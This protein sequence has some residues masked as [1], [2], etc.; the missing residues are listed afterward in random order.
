MCPAKLPIRGV[1]LLLILTV[2]G[3]LIPLVSLHAQALSRAEAIRLA[4]ARNPEVEAARQAWAGSR[5]RARQAGALPD[6]ELKF[7]FEELAEFGGLDEYGERTIGLTQRFES[8]L[9]WWHGRQAGHQRADATRLAVFEMAKLDISLRAKRAYDRIAL[10]LAVLQHTR[11]NLSLA[12]DIQHKAHIRFAA[13]DVPQLDV[14][15]A[16]VEAGR[17]TNRLTAV[18]NGLSVARTEL[19]ALLARPL[20]TPFTV[21]DSLV[22]RP[23]DKNLDQLTEAALAQRPDLL[24]TAL[25]LRAL[26][27]QQAA[28][29]AAYMPDLNVGLARQRLRD[30]ARE[31]DFWH[32]S[33]GLEVPLWA[34]SR[35]RGERAAAQA[36]VAQAAATGAALRY[37]VLLET[38][39]AYLALNTAAEQVSLFQGRILP[40]AER[41]FAVARRSYD[42]GKA[43]YLELLETQRTWIEARM[44]YAHVLFD[45]H[46]AT[47]ALER[48]IAGPL[49]AE[50]TG[51]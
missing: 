7:E 19:N 33:F 37:R 34:F 49:T 48:A 42:E 16:E 38:R 40:V 18:Q 11:Q 41:T 21:V 22:Y 6:P 15:R 27:S 36:A 17:A 39:E 28:A 50:P 13:G 3:G 30:G 4:L 26:Q 44:E 9:K 14:M 10:Q 20:Q 47:A 12:Q 35:Q 5:A 45:Y 25:R 43:T 24:G 1:S 32:L 46:A 31:D 23:F 2:L 8:P 29:T 51:L